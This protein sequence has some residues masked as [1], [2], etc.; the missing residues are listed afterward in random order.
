M[1]QPIFMT[2]E[3]W[4]LPI[5]RP[6]QQE[7]MMQMLL[8]LFEAGSDLRNPCLLTS[9]VL[10]VA[11]VTFPGRHNIWKLQSILLQ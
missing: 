11:S 10:A 8:I 1:M 5:S 3:V 2:L 4:L 9:D 6:T 7:P